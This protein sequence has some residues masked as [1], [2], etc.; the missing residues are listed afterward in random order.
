MDPMAGTARTP[1]GGRA[2]GGVTPAARQTPARPRFPVRRALARRGVL[3]GFLRL[4]GGYW[5]GP[6]CWRAW[7]LTLGLVLL[8][9]ALVPAWCT[10]RARGRS[11]PN[12]A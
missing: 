8:T 4:A 10:D 5:H 2:Q 7:G 9:V 11:C 3:H 1:A 12:L 6:G